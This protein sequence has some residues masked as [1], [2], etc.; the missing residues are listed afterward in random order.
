MS[1]YVDCSACACLIR[2]GEPSCPFCGTSQRPV[3]VLASRP[4]LGLVLG[5]GLASFSCTGGEGDSSSTVADT[6]TEVDTAD[7]PNT[8]PTE[9]QEADAVTYAG[10]D[11]WDTTESPGATTTT[12][13]DSLDT[14]EA[15][16][17][18]YA[19]PDETT[20]IG[21]ATTTTETTGSTSATTDSGEVCD[22]ITE[23]ASAI[24]NACNSD[25]DCPAD[26]TCQPFQG[27]VLQMTCQVLC[28]QTCQCPA[29]LSCIEIADKSGATWG[30]CG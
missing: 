2:S 22:P 18:T 21:D 7:G 30:Q 14:Q 25:L 20:T 16:A 1:V 13:N 4:R 8:Y 6:T 5:L 23:D 11:S 24:N 3:S 19:G 10:P 12:T 28:E 15:D 17:V 27:I 26:Y 9:T 29:G